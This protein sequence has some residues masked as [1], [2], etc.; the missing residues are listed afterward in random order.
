MYT[1]LC[2][3]VLSHVSRVRLSDPMD[4]SLP[5][6]SVHGILQARNWSGLPFPSPE[7]LPHPGIELTSLGLLHWQV[8]SFPIASCQFSSVAQSCP[9]LR[10]PMK[11]N[12]PGLLVHYQLPELT[13]THV[14]RVSDA[15]QP[16]HPV[17]P[18]SSCPQSFP[19]SGSFKRSQ[20]F[21][22]GGQSFSFNMSPWSFSFNMSPS[23][24]YSGL[25]SFRM[26]WLD[27]LA[28]QGTLKSLLQHHSSKASIL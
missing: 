24:E 1:L 28:V 22:S 19:A 5:G 11:R 23:N 12:T 17:V 27:L 13:Q 15:I 4:C 8:G 25:I 14:R 2:C 6:S 18:F 3:A 7:D 16:S 9:A 21:L 10:D 26:D 20:L